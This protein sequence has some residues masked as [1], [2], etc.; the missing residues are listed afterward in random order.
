MQN[1]Y[2]AK[3]GGNINIFPDS[4]TVDRSTLDAAKAFLQITHLEPRLEPEELMKRRSFFK[5]N[6]T[7]CTSAVRSVCAHAPLR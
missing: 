5:R 4:R 7:L 3:F 6:T 1:F 2:G